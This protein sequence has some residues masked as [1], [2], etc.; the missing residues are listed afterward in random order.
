MPEHIYD[1][2]LYLLRLHSSFLATFFAEGTLI[3]VTRENVSP[4]RL[5][6]FLKVDSFDMILNLFAGSTLCLIVLMRSGL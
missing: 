4:A 5:K 3:D 2:Y 6:I 1:G